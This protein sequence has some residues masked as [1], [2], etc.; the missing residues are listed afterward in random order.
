MT[1][2]DKSEGRKEGRID[3]RKTSLSLT[4]LLLLF[5]SSLSVSGDMEKKKKGVGPFLCLFSRVLG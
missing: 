3:R 5:F 1:L 2:V 4:H